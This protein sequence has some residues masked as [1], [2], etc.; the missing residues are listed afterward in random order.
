MQRNID[1]C[2]TGFFFKSNN[3]YYIHKT[4]Q[5]YNVLL[6]N[7]FNELPNFITKCLIVDLN[8]RHIYF[9]FS[10]N[11][12]LTTTTNKIYEDILNR[13][14]SNISVA[15]GFHIISS[16]IS[17]ETSDGNQKVNIIG[18]Q[19]YDLTFTNLKSEI[20]ME[21]KFSFIYDQISGSYKEMTL[22]KNSITNFS[23]LFTVHSEAHFLQ[24]NALKGADMQFKETRSNKLAKISKS[25]SLNMN[26]SQAVNLSKVFS[27]SSVLPVTLNLTYNLIPLTSPSETTKKNFL[28]KITKSKKAINDTLNFLKSLAVEKSLKDHLETLKFSTTNLLK[29]ISSSQNNG[30]SAFPDMEFIRHVFAEELKRFSVFLDRY[31]QLN[32]IDSVGIELKFVN[33]KKEFQEFIQTTNANNRQQY[34]VGELSYLVIEGGGHLCVEYFCFRDLNLALNLKQNNIIAKFT[35]KDNIGNYI[36]LSPLSQIHYDLQRSIKSVQMKGEVVVFKEVKEVNIT[37]D[38]SLLFFNVDA[39]LGNEYLIPLYVESSLDAMFQDDP[40][41]FDFHGNMEKSNELKKDIQNALQDYFKDLEETL[42]TRNI[43]MKISKFLSEKLMKEAVNTTSTLLEKYQ[44]LKMELEIIDSNLTI[45]R[46]ALKRERETY[47]QSI[48]HNSN[49]SKNHIHRLVEQCQP[50]LCNSSCLPGLEKYICSKQR[51][52][53]LIDQQCLLQ[54]VSTTFYQQVKV[55]KKV[56]TTKYEKKYYCWNEC[57]VLRNLIRKEKRQGIPAVIIGA[58]IYEKLESAVGNIG[59][60]IGG[61]F[62][63]PAGAIVREFIDKLFGSCNRYCADEYVPVSSYLNLL[64]YEKQPVTKKILKTKCESSV[65]YVDGDTSSV[66]ECAVKSRCIKVYMDES[67]INKQ[68]ECN[69]F[70]KSFINYSLDKISI[71]KS[72]QNFSRTSF[73]MMY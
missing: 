33:F 29:A 52:I 34:N 73:F 40:L 14:S 62:G 16:K 18:K 59:A 3:T 28:S 68:L 49:I 10:R 23:L 57:S 25:V 9:G 22:S 2:L 19:N 31:L 66:Y 26:I 42:N 44:E 24:L 30:L 15:I 63:G 61:L 13:F 21:G 53:Y 47:K 38:K 70:R 60:E 56:P 12:Y 55:H 65:R 27:L 36:Q 50:K 45:T 5:I 43:S 6:P 4:N 51:Q 58:S 39:K 41:Y 35:K 46:S 1:N 37:I 11:N 7:S 32:I 67:C 72:F 64:E 20:N 17:F 48:E 54:N 69:D 71:E 8:D